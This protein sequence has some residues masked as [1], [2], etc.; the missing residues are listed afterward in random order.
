M[1]DREA[2]LRHFLVDK[3][4]IPPPAAASYARRLVS[5]GFDD[6]HSLRVSVTLHRPVLRARTN[7]QED[8]RWEEARCFMN[9]GH[10]RAMM[11]EL[12]SLGGFS[13][14]KLRVSS[15]ASR[16]SLATVESGGLETS[17]ESEETVEPWKQVVSPIEVTAQE[18]RT[19]KSARDRPESAPFPPRKAA[20]EQR[21]AQSHQL[22]RRPM[23][24][25]LRP[26]N[27]TILNDAGALRLDDFV[28]GP[29]GAWHQPSLRHDLLPLDEL[30]RGA[31]G[32]V[33]RALH[34]PSGVIVAV[35]RVAIDDDKRRN[36]MI[37][38]L[39]ALHGL[40]GSTGLSARA[41][42]GLSPPAESSSTSEHRAAHTGGRFV[43]DYLDAYV[44]P[45]TDSLCLVLE[46]MNCGSLED[47]KRRSAT[48]GV[49]VDERLLSRV[50]FCVSSALAYIHS[51]RELHRDIKPSNI[52]LNLRG[53][54]KVSDY[55]CAKALDD[56]SS[57]ASTFMGTVSYMSPERVSTTGYSYPSDVWSLGISLLATALG[58]NP[59][60]HH[61]VYWDIAHAINNLP[62]P[63]PPD[64]Y[65][66]SFGD[67]V[68]RCLRKD[69]TQR[70]TA[71]ELLNHPFARAGRRTSIGPIIARM[72]PPINNRKHL[73]ALV[74]AL[75][76]THNYP[77]SP[78][79]L[80]PTSTR[81]RFNKFASQL[82]VPVDRL[83]AVYDDVLRRKRLS[84]PHH[85]AAGPRSNV[86]NPISF[87]DA[88][89]ATIKPERYTKKA[90]AN[91]S[92]SLTVSSHAAL[93]TK[94]RPLEANHR[95]PRP[96]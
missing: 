12:D 39:R 9:E 77:A 65:S 31:G 50:A 3:V 60:S 1:V 89:A 82:G 94:L 26:E 34:V 66:A 76:D 21:R 75:L 92:P 59:Y 85:A 35:K 7:A 69:P 25:E 64:S 62:V 41:Q 81:Q 37:K 44:D 91:T 63:R 13:P 14:V 93:I 52:L 18:R 10:V 53:E 27:S 40:K 55:G 4:R 58:H 74:A 67:F 78:H 49:A 6:I 71:A 2:A 86:V 45:S 48:D 24:I 68:D 83:R 90:S 61:K 43:V 8:L 70:P 17:F 51:R 54:V 36:Q 72:R 5:D 46:F 22:P 30:G 15:R 80:D 73:V 23:G 47:F 42:H 29:D 16:D 33:Q 87:T 20:V 28:V 88:L 11:A 38:E 57:L 84:P 32:C 19:T 79:A 56:D 96:F 95:R